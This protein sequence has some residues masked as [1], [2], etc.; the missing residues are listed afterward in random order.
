MQSIH[1]PYT[2]HYQRKAK[3]FLDYLTTL[4][5]APKGC[6]TSYLQLCEFFRFLEN[7]KIFSMNEIT[8][9]EVSGFYAFLKERKSLRNA[10]GLT[11]ETVFRTMR[12]VQKYFG[13]ALE[14][15][16]IKTNPASHL[17]LRGKG[18]KNERRIFTQEQIRQL[19]MAANTLQERAILHIAYGC[20]LRVSE[21]TALNREDIKETE[22]LIVVSRGKNNKRRLVPV[23]DKVMEEL[24]EFLFSDE[25]KSM[26]NAE[27]VFYD[28]AANRMQGDTLNRRLKD[29][30][31][32]TDFGKKLTHEELTK[33]G[34]HTLRHSIATHLLENGMSLHQVQLF[35]GHS[36]AETTEIYTHVNQGLINN[37][38]A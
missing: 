5:Y 16:K 1:T 36:Q 15:A 25:K 21:V 23:S 14:S 11:R 3:S 22:N 17:K 38:M 33:T 4:G 31:R 19:Y 32:R 29:M 2:E 18:Q 28:Y 10:Q 24:K 9:F 6:R 7:R 37:L 26:V 20:G 8:P 12:C 30:I 34:I 35:L 13:Y 27:Y